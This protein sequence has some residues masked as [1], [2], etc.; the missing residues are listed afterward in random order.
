MKKTNFINRLKDKILVYDGAMGTML[1]KMGLSTNEC[2]ELYNLHHKEVIKE[3]HR[4]YIEAGCDIIQTNTF[5][6]NKIKLSSYGHGDLVEEINKQAVIIAREAAG[7]EGLVA[8]DIGPTGK[9]LYPL[10]E[11]TFE[12]VYDGFYQ[13]AKALIEAGVDIINIETMSDIREAKAAV[14]AVRDIGDIPIICT[15]TFQE[16]L[17]TLTGSDPET[18]VTILEAMGVDVI[19]ANCGF[20]PEMMVEVLKRM[21][22]VSQ[23]PLMVQPNAGLPKLVDGQSIYDMTPEKMV[24]YVDDL[25]LAGANIIGGCCGTTPHHLRLIVERVSHLKPIPKKKITFSKLASGTDTLLIG[26]GHPTRVI[27]GHINPTAKDYLIQAIKEENMGILTEHAVKQVEAGANIIGINLGVNTQQE[28]RMMKKAITEIQQAVRVPLSIDTVN[29]DA[30]EEGLK[31]YNGKP[32][33]NSTSAKDDALN[34]VIKLAK[35]YGAS[36]VGL[37]LD[38]NG[39]PERAEDRF[40]IAEKIVRTAVEQGIR[41]ED[42]FIDTLVLTAGAQQHVALECLKAIKLV[43][44]R[45]GVKTLLGVENI[46]HGLPNR[47]MLNNTFLAMALEAGLDLPIINPYYQSS[48]YTIKSA[49]V[50]MGKDKNA[51]DFVQRFKISNNSDTKIKLEDKTPIEKKPL[52][53]LMC[54]IKNGDKKRALPKVEELIADNIQPIDIIN[55]GIIPA[56]EEIGENYEKQI[57]FLPQLLL[58]A[59]TAQHIFQAVKGHVKETTDNSLGTLI[60]A[61]V[62]G[63]IHDIGKNIVSIMLENHGFRVI[64]LG[65]NVDNEAI[66]E[67][68]IKERADIIGLSALMTTTMQE[69]KNISNLLK[70]KGIEI[71]IMVG[72]AVVTDG[73]AKEIGAHYAADAIQAVKVAKAIMEGK[74]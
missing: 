60:I 29:Y 58:A 48:W 69:M 73:Y 24:N 71:P 54:I 56:L 3:I 30:M 16:N 6:G 7:E 20:G 28:S 12:E 11:V 1:Q 63:D 61:T 31:V 38:E 2:P 13:Q 27:G 19:G 18:V 39:I 41:K 57:Y 53:E 36:I 67:T 8:G 21:Q 43:K 26:E 59:E 22:Q 34:R 66:I 32:L 65:K 9:L 14:M 49:D 17:R 42:I 37:T 46:S 55:G 10:G 70:K 5:G 52:E 44:E 74:M 64:D 40:K 15:M 51:E 4:Q 33:L 25:V 72:G 47:G 35:G 23:S 50:L 45:L 68:A 62:K